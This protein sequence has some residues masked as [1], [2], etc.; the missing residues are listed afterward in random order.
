MKKKILTLS[1][2]D[3]F[4]NI[5]SGK[6]ISNQYLTIFFKKLPSFTDNNTLNMS[7]ITKKKL[8]NA[9]F[10]NKIKRR[11]RNIIKSAL[12]TANLNLK[13]SYLFMAKKNVFDDNYKL[14]KENIFR[15]LKRI[16]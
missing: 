2:N 11:L 14:I 6:K 8:G 5:L 15:E 13:Y 9:V 7:I 4:K 3:D 1:K 16:R 10:R 12:D